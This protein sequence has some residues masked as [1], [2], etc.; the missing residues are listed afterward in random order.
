MAVVRLLRE[1]ILA[2]LDQHT[3]DIVH[4]H[5]PSLCGLAA[6]QAANARKVSFVYEIRAF[7]EDPPVDQNKT[8]P[9]SPRY[10]ISRG[11]EGYVA[12]RADAVVGIARHILDDLR[13]RG[14]TAEKIFHVSHG[15]HARR[16]FGWP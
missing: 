2:L 6:A 14:F 12:R 3:F 15:G 1:Q 8:R 16:F 9:T 7:W 4:A 11:L 13:G 5:S 10:L